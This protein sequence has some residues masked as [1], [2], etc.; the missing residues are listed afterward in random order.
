M[1]VVI[2]LRQSQKGFAMLNSLPVA[3]L[4]LALVSCQATVATTVPVTGTV[5]VAGKPA[6]GAQVIF[7]PLGDAPI[8]PRGKVGPDGR[9]SLTTLTSD[10]GAAPGEYR[11]TIEW[12]LSA[13]GDAPATNRLS[14]SFANPA[15]SGLT[16]TVNPAATDVP[17]FNLSR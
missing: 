1:L 4:A 5:N 3:V 9:F 16:A 11:V 6:A 8:K 14:A 17:T 13:G 10:D 7:H 2:T 15:T 12:W